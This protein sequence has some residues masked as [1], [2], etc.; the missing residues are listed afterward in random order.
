[1]MHPDLALRPMHP[2]DEA[3]LRRVYA[4]VR[5]PE[6]ALTGWE[7]A[8]TQA[9]LRMQ[10]DAQ[11]VHYQK[12]YAHARFDIVERA[13]TPVGRL[14]VAREAQE[15]RVVDIALLAQYRKQGIGSTLLRA[16]LREAAADG[17]RVTIHVEE[18]N[19]AQSLYRRLGF[20]QVGTHGLYRLMEWRAASGETQ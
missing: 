10:F 6:I 8:S 9:F 1:M 12:Y 14:Y 17:L 3:L 4:E 2:G 15:I 5:A 11:H 16:L 13:G 20:T 7:A 18:N 19:P